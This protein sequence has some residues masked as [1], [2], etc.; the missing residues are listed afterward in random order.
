VY[1][2]LVNDAP[3]PYQYIEVELA[4][5]FGWTLE[6]IENLSLQRVND[7]FQTI[8]GRDKARAFKRRAKK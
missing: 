5:R 4:E 7:I 6:Y 8:D 3:A 2:A 1:L